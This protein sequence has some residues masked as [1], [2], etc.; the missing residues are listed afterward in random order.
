MDYQPQFLLDSDQK[1]HV[2]GDFYLRK[3]NFT[4][5]KEIFQQLSQKHPHFFQFPFSLGKIEY[6]LGN[7]DQAK[8]YLESVRTLNPF[9]KQNLILLYK[10]YLKTE[11]NQQALECMV[12]VYLLSKEMDDPMVGTYKKKIRNLTKK[13]LPPM[14][15]IAKNRFTKERI[16][17]LNQLLASY[18]QNFLQ[19]PQAQALLNTARSTVA[20]PLSKQTVLEMSNE[21]T[22]DSEDLKIPM[23]SA[24]PIQMIEPTIAPAIEPA[25]EPKQAAPAPAEPPPHPEPLSEPKPIVAAP[26]PEAPQDTSKDISVADFQRAGVASEMENHLLFKSLDSTTIE[27][28]QKFSNVH[29]FEEGATIYSPLD[30]IYGFSCVLSGK[31]QLLYQGKQLLELEAGSIIDEP[32]LSVGTKYFFE[33]R[34]MAPT[35]ILIVNKSALMTLCK[36]QHELGLHFLWHFY[37]SLSLK[38]NAMFENIIYQNPTH[39][40]IWALDRIQEISRKKNLLPLEDHIFKTNFTNRFYQK[41]DFIFRNHSHADTFYI[42]LEGDVSLSHPTS[43]D[44]IQLHAGDFFSETSL[45]SNSF[46]HAYDAKVISENANLVLIDRDQLNALNIRGERDFHRMFEAFW[47]IF[48]LKYF[49]FANFIYNLN[50]S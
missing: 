19:L 8:N 15:D 11:N 16:L 12:D 43:G 14:D 17:H 41:G 26:E 36:R 38:I 33:A 32:E 13:I 48:S 29:H 42:L 6:E 35:N 46:E 4:F 22:P 45:L 24:E 1:L 18:E 49:E 25:E 20:K 21:I 2:L 27:K 40:M 39:E 23:P 30:L 31:V 5:A 7:I 47:R 10:C 44:E 28:I 34:A 50:R 9:N 37:K 3:G